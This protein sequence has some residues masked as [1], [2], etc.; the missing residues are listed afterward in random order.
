MSLPVNMK[1]L[2]GQIKHAKRVSFTLTANV[3]STSDFVRFT[4]GGDLSYISSEEESLNSPFHQ[5]D[6]LE[7]VIIL[8][9]RYTCRTYRPEPGNYAS[10]SRLMFVK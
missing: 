6:I 5:S 10:Y 3:H 7:T 2:S 9:E 8:L 1:I 4:R